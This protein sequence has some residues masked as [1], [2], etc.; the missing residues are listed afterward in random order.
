VAAA[1]GL[2]TTFIEGNLFV[3]G[4]INGP[5]QPI[6]PVGADPFGIDDSTAAITSVFT[7]AASGLE[8]HI[9]CGIYKITKPIAI[10]ITSK[11]APH[12]GGGG[13][14]CTILWF[15]GTNGISV[16]FADQWT[17]ALFSDMTLAT[18]DTT[19]SYTALQWNTPKAVV[20]GQNIAFSTNVVRNVLYRGLDA[21]TT[22]NEYWGTGFTETNVSFINIDHG[23][24]WGAKQITSGVS[25]SAASPAVVTMTN[26]FPANFPVILG[27]TLPTGLTSGKVY[28]VTAPTSAHFNLANVPGGAALNTSG[29]ATTTATIQAYG[30]GN[31]IS[32]QGSTALPSY[33]VVVNIHGFNAGG[34]YQGLYY[35][36]FLQGVVVDSGTNIGCSI[37]VT[38]ING[39]VGTP[40]ELA[41]ADS[42][43]ETAVAAVN[44]YGFNGLFVHHNT[45]VL[46]GGVGLQG[47]GN[48][49]FI[50]HNFLQFSSLPPSGA[51]TV[52]INMNVSTA[53]RGTIEANSIGNANT[54]IA[55]TPATYAYAN[56]LYNFEPNGPVKYSINASALGTRI[57]DN[58]LGLTSGLP[59]CNGGTEGAQFQVYDASGPTYNGTL[60]GSG[61]AV[62]PVTCNGT[63][64]TT[65]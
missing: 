62:V 50:D 4:A 27:G 23:G 10:S 25:I 9:P 31:A 64:W 29:S 15:S 61:G 48:G 17:S 16:S 24:F 42:A 30:L 3:Y 1:I 57:I 41:I 6:Q 7:Q 28:F 55:V 51:A 38:T 5:G 33:S 59:A 21:Y 13:Q 54:D 11:A 44:T 35:G 40:D 37:G 19:G 18:D 39:P 43:F 58:Y 52:G 26:N 65:H 47:F 14:D 49:F 45:F 60:S 34:C 36:D 32:L 22:N 2:D 12:I 53:S 8:A 46:D 20:Y 63:N 56:I